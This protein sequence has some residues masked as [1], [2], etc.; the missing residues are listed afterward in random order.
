MPN[1]SRICSDGIPEAV[2]YMRRRGDGPFLAG[3]VKLDPA[4]DKKADIRS[5][6]ERYQDIKR[7]VKDVEELNIQGEEPA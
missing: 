6:K 5:I 7:A 4:P 1:R 2:S 3:P